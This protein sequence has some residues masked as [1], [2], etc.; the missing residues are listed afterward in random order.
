MKTALAV[1]IS[2]SAAAFTAYSQQLAG[3]IPDPG[4]TGKKPQPIKKLDSV[5]WDLTAHKLVW[6]VHNG[7]MVNGQFVPSSEE[8]YA[9]SPDDATMAYATDMRGFDKNEAATLQRLLDVLSLYCAESVVW[10]DEGQGTP[11]PPGARRATPPDTPPT[12][13]PEAPGQKPVRVGE[14]HPHK[15]AYHVPDSDYVA[16]LVRMR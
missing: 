6:V 9:I 5:T 2:L 12:K 3:R 15:P 11:L 10:W 8:R 1:L 13:L 4:D 16:E 14:P 7:M